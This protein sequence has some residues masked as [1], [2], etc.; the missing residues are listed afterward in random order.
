MMRYLADIKNDHYEKCMEIWQ[1]L[2]INYETNKAEHTMTWAILMPFYK[3]TG[4]CPWSGAG[5][6]E[7]KII[8]FGII[9][10]Y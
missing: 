7:V 3:N 4:L 10:L 6:R 2:L 8:V 1:I 9:F 5:Q